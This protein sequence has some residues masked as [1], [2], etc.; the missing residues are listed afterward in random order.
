M[1]FKSE[2]ETKCL[3]QE[4]ALNDSNATGVKKHTLPFLYWVMSA[5]Q[6]LPYV[7]DPKHNRVNPYKNYKE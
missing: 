4:M 7:K 2:G 6:Y 1:V 5:M 3:H